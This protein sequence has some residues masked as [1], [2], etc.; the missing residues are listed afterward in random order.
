[1]TDFLELSKEAYEASTDYIDT[2]YRKKWDTSLR[3]FRNEHAAESKY[4]S[5]EFAARS[6]IYRPKTRGIIRKNEAA[7]AMAMFSNADLVECSP[8]N[9]DDSMNVASA[10]CMKEILQFRLS[11]TIRS[12]ELVIGA[13][14]DAQVTGSVCSYQYWEYEKDR[15]GRKV[16]DRPCI[17]L[18]PIENMRIDSGASWI[19]PVG[20]TPFLADIIPMRVCEVKARMRSVDDKT[21]QPRWRQLEDS[22]ILRALPDVL[23]TTRRSR[24]GFQQDPEL[25]DMPDKLRHFDV[26]WVMRWFMRDS[27]NE[28]YA[29]YTMGTEELLTEPMPIHEVYFHGRRPY[30]IGRSIIETHKALSDGVPELIKPLQMEINDVAN[31]RLDNVK[32]AL[33]KRWI[34]ARGRQTDVPSLVRNVPGGVTLTN[35]P[36]SDVMAHDWN[37]V[38]A[39]SYVEHDRLNSE[40]DDVAGNFSPSTRVANNAVNDTLGGSRMALQSAGIMTDYLLMTVM[41]TWWTPVLRQLVLLE[42]YYETD[43]I[44]LNV[45]AQKA[46][47]FPRFGMSSITDEMLMKGV[48]LQ[49]NAGLG[50]ANPTDRFNKFIMATNA[51]VQIVKTAPPGANVTEMIKEIYSNAGYR[52]GNRFFSEKS[53]PRLLQAM[54]FIDQLQQALNSKQMEQQVEMR[55]VQ[56]KIDGENRRK[57]SELQVDSYRI[58]G[59]LMLR[60]AELAVQDK[61]LAIEAAKVEL[62]KI[63][64]IL[65]HQGEGQEL[66][67]R[68]AEMFARLEEL[69]VSLA[70]EREKLKGIALKIRGD[71]QNQA[72]QLANKRAEGWQNAQAQTQT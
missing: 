53:D 36:K 46:Q 47:L 61:E 19:D 2:N 29:Y 68:Q 5:P 7:G 69:S 43:E 28:D 66:G 65:E 17:E 24:L 3:A 63:E 31:Q 55:M 22:A 1:M 57:S 8:E 49:I 15:H 44:V 42:Q 35:D 25:S 39:S 23:E 52:N 6:R 21:K 10:A 45:C 20:T 37:D 58:Q 33:N 50:A 54:E 40:L 38:T 4:N 51:A 14:Q 18:R 26:V 27:Q 48:T 41:E 70:V 59:D 12:F 60:E 16:K 67:M 71:T 9:E 30:V 34:V 11:R 32:F 62:Q 13:L 56:L 72:V 64:L